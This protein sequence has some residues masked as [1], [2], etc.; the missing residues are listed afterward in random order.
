V[1]QY[2]LDGVLV[3]VPLFGLMIGLFAVAGTSSELGGMGGVLLFVLA[4]GLSWGV[5]AWWPSTHGGQTP[6]MGWL[7]LR[8]VTEAGGAPGIGA[9]SVRGVLLLVDGSFF[10][11]VGF[12]IMMSTSRHQR[13]GDIAASTYVVR[14]S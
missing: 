2:P 12:V 13:L 7:D 1:G 4:F 6:A 10:G 14:A 8:I 3:G 11:L 9:L 5:H